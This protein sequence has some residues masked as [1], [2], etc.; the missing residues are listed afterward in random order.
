MTVSIVWFRRDLRLEDNDVLAHA[1]IMTKQ[2]IPVYIHAPGEDGP[3]AMGAAARW[4]LHHSLAALDAALRKQRSR[5]VIRRASSSLAGLRAL[6]KETGA[7]LVCW[8][9][10]YE[11]AEVAR[12]DAIEA[13]MVRA[14][15]TVQT[16]P[17]HLL[18]EPDAVATGA[19]GPYK[20]FTPYARSARAKLALPNPRPAPT[21]MRAVP[22]TLA[23]QPLASLKLLPSPDW[24]ARFAHR[25]QPG[26]AGA[27]RQLRALRRRLARY[28]TDRDRPAVDGTSLLSPHLH[29]GEVTPARVWRE[30]SAQAAG[31]RTPGLARGAESFQ[32][33]LLWREFAHHVLHH[34]P[35]TPER[36]LDARFANFPWRRSS[37]LLRAWQRGET[38][39]PMV[40]TGLHELWATGYMHNRARMIVASFL[41][42]H[43]RIHWHDGA[44]WFWDTLVDADLAN[45]TLN[46]QW[47]AGC[48]ADAAPYFRIFNPVLQGRRFDP[49]GDYVARWLPALKK[50][51]ARYRHAPWQAP[52]RVLASAGLHLGRDYPYPVI[53]PDL[54]RREA[55]DAFRRWRQHAP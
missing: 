36:P 47:V 9:R 45:N 31:H 40:D 53:D 16:F 41:T 49:G 30:V 18:L 7:G 51:P 11:P 54:G 38:G 5:L 29:F 35:R 28:A 21:H 34:F 6:V 1:L 17:G 32:R 44:R 55:L 12:E 25:W 14:G 27:H 2:V 39:I 10:L 50:L 3:W 46:W 33:E 52:A 15:V 8:H 4:W 24:A 26:E 19:G 22:R 43:L 48:G 13:A 37:S 20:V 42:K 23:S